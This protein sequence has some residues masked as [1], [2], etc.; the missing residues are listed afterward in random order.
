MTTT[1][2]KAMRR[3]SRLLDEDETS[4]S[5]VSVYLVRQEIEKLLKYGLIS[6]CTSSWASPVLVIVKK[7]HSG[8]VANI[9][10]ATDLRKLNAVTEMDSGAIGEMAEIIDKFNGRP[11]AMLRRGVGILQFPHTQA[12]I[13]AYAV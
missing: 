3:I 1:F 2:G 8:T 13:A 6:P 11:Y 5:P 4:D 12:Q 9:K 7:D 10:L